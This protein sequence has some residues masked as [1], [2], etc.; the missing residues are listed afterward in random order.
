MTEYVVTKAGGHKEPFNAE[1][2]VGSLR[3]AGAS[4]QTIERIMTRVQ[5]DLD[6]GMTTHSIYKHAFLVLRKFERPVAARYSLRRALADFG[7]TGFPFEDFISELFK[8]RGFETAVR[9]NVKGSCTSHEVDVVAWNENK[10]LMVE[11]KFHNQ[12]TIKT[13]LKVILYVKAR[14]DDLS[15]GVFDYGRSRPLDEGWVITNTKFS[16]HAIEYGECAGVRMLGWN[17]PEKGNLQDLVNDFGLHP[18]SCLLS[19]TRS[20]KEILLAHNIVL[21]K[22]V[23]HRKAELLSYGFSSSAVTQIITEA[24]MVC[25]LSNSAS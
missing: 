8:A 14:F 20:Q 9:Q 21:C 5:D 19:L 11:A 6:E 1:K 13:D 25:Q 4:S 12:F 2:L 16:H 3:R 10:M 17:Y 18:I 15:L 7:P 23:V 24:E 22:D